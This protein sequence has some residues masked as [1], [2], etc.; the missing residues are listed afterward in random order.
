MST[1]F[2]KIY[3]PGPSQW[4]VYLREWNQPPFYPAMGWYYLGAMQ[5]GTDIE[6][7]N[8]NRDIYVD[9]LGSRT[10]VDSAYMG[11]MA[12]IRGVTIK[13]NEEVFQR[14]MD[15]FTRFDNS[16][17]NYCYPGTNGSLLNAHGMG[18][19]LCVVSRFA[20][21][22]LGD[23]HGMVQIQADRMPSAYSFPLCQFMNP[24][25][26]LG[27]KPKTPIVTLKA[28]PYQPPTSW[29]YSS[30][31]QLMVPTIP[32]DLINLLTSAQAF[33]NCSFD[34]PTSP[35]PTYKP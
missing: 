26:R 3:V 5:D 28:I 9:E 19:G 16:S 8:Q 15:T 25:F 34:V 32:N 2:P 11:S 14:M 1:Q 10:P 18:I 4:Y 33:G 12:Y 35:V 22:K 31:Y 24:S 30:T 29:G 21:K 6:F 20:F 17:L 27:I 23:S 13:Y 7:V